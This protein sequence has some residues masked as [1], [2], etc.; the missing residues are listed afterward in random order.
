MV[1][2]NIRHIHG[3]GAVFKDAYPAAGQS[4]NDGTSHSRA[5]V[6]GAHPQL[7][8]NRFPYIADTAGFQFILSQDLDGHHQV[9][10]DVTQRVARNDDLLHILISGRS[11]SM[12]GLC[13]GTANRFRRMVVRV[14]GVTS[15]GVVVVGRFIGA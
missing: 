12:V 2:A 4:A 3:T 10:I 11:M 5:K 9:S 13:V 7:V 8:G 15:R 14:V 1:S 6:T